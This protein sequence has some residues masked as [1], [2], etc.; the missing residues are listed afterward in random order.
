MLKKLNI[1]KDKIKTLSLVVDY[2]PLYVGLSKKSPHGKMLYEKMSPALLKI[3]NSGKDAQ[4][5]KKYL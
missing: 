4:I 5:W 1:S 2:S 3:I